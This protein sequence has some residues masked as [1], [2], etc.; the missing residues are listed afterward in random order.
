MGDYEI[1]RGAG[2]CSACG[3]TLGAGEAYFSAVLDRPAGLQRVD[4][5]NACWGAPPTEALC[6]FR[7]RVPPPRQPK[8]RLLVDDATLLTFFE[9]LEDHAADDLRRDFRFVLALIL[10]RRRVLKYERSLRDEG[11]DHW[12]LRRA[13]AE[14]TYRLMDR[15][16]DEQRITLLM[17]ELGAILATES[18][19]GPDVDAVAPPEPADA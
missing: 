12:L 11:V 3:R 7:S 6:Y 16:L 8:R 19:A 2:Q 18:P 4:T 10:M 14:T 5:C 9:R 1:S 17:G 13:G 15:R